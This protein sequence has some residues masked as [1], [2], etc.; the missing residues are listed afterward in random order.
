MKIIKHNPVSLLTTY[1]GK[2]QNN[3]KFN[4]PLSTASVDNVFYPTQYSNEKNYHIGVNFFNF[5]SIGKFYKDRGKLSPILNRSL[6]TSQ[7]N[8]QFLVI[9]Q[10]S[11]NEA[12]SEKML[13]NGSTVEF[14]NT[15]STAMRLLNQN[16]SSDLSLIVHDISNNYFSSNNSISSVMTLGTENT[17]VNT[18]SGM[19]LRYHDNAVRNFFI[20]GYQIVNE[21][22]GLNLRSYYNTFENECLVHDELNTL[23]SSILGRSIDMISNPD[24]LYMISVPFMNSNTLRYNSF[25]ISTP[26]TN[27]TQAVGVP[28]NNIFNTN[29]I[30]YPLTYND[31]SKEARFLSINLHKYVRN[32]SKFTQESY[33]LIF[34]QYKV[35]SDT[36]STANIVQTDSQLIQSKDEIANNMNYNVGFSRTLSNQETFFSLIKKEKVSALNIKRTQLFNKEFFKDLELIQGLTFEMKIS[37]LYSRLEIEFNKNIELPLISLKDRHIFI[38]N[39]QIKFYNSEDVEIYPL[40]D[41]SEESFII[42]FIKTTQGFDVFIND[43][44]SELIINEADL[45]TLYGNSSLIIGGVLTL[46]YVKLYDNV[47]SISEIRSSSASSNGGSSSMTLVSIEGQNLEFVPKNIMNKSAFPVYLVPGMIS[48]YHNAIGVNTSGWD[49]TIS[50]LN[51]NNTAIW[52]RRFTG[53]SKPAST[54]NMLN[55]QE[56]GLYYLKVTG[57]YASGAYFR[58]N[59]GGIKDVGKLFRLN[60]SFFPINSKIGIF[61]NENYSSISLNDNII[62]GIYPNNNGDLIAKQAF[63][64]ENIKYSFKFNFKADISF[65][66]PIYEYRLKNASFDVYISPDGNDTTGNGAYYNPWKT[67]RN[68][69]RGQLIGLLPGTYSDAASGYGQA[70]NIGGYYTLHGLFYNA[71]STPDYTRP[72]SKYVIPANLRNGVTGFSGRTGESIFISA[73]EPG[74]V[75]IAMGNTSSRDYPFYQGNAGFHYDIVFANINVQASRGKSTNHACS[76]SRWLQFVLFVNMEFRETGN[77]SLQYHNDSSNPVGYVNCTFTGGRQSNYSGVSREV[78]NLALNNE[79]KPNSKSAIAV[80]DM[81]L[82]DFQILRVLTD[83]PLNSNRLLYNDGTYNYIKLKCDDLTIDDP[84]VDDLIV[85]KNLSDF[86]FIDRFEYTEFNSSIFDI[87]ET[88]EKIQFTNFDDIIFEELVIINSVETYM[89][90]IINQEYLISE[91]KNK[92]IRLKSDTKLHN[93]ETKISFSMSKISTRIVEDVETII[94]ED[95]N[96]SKLITER[97]EDYVE[98]KESILEISH[99]LIK[100]ALIQGLNSKSK[101]FTYVDTD[102]VFTK[103]ENKLIIKSNNFNL[104]SM[105]IKDYIVSNNNELKLFS[106]DTDMHD[107]N[108][109]LYDYDNKKYCVIFNGT[110]DKHDVYLLE[111]KKYQDVSYIPDPD[112]TQ[113]E[114]YVPELDEEGNEI[115]WEAPLIPIYNDRTEFEFIDSLLDTVRKPLPANENDH[116]TYL[117]LYYDSDNLMKIKRLYLTDKIEVFDTNISNTFNQKLIPH[118]FK[119]EKYDTMDQLLVNMYK[120]GDEFRLLVN[121]NFNDNYGRV[122]TE[123]RISY[124]YNLKKD[125]FVETEIVQVKTTSI[126]KDENDQDIEVEVLTNEFILTGI[127]ENIFKEKLVNSTI[128]LNIF[129]DSKSILVK[130]ENNNFINYGKSDIVIHTD[131]E[132]KFEL[133]IKI[134]SDI[135]Q[136]KNYFDNAKF[137]FKIYKFLDAYT[138]TNNILREI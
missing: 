12:H 20:S 36:T 99:N 54:I 116:S 83:I 69:Q 85:V 102:Y 136:V 24:E 1:Y 73:V 37:R 3:F 76:Y 47:E 42:K 51:Q 122:N 60:S 2:N 96:E 67:L 112:A 128:T 74:T 48:L 70:L 103:Y 7:S 130:D 15:P 84:I 87:D 27:W 66:I 21:Q 98:T 132:A 56:F 32:A 89:P 35:P 125:I 100:D 11:T 19:L 123:D 72:N 90:I 93:V 45:I 23:R 97:E 107:I 18:H 25:V 5:N 71:F 138:F 127:V 137:I 114:D 88:F 86:I 108:T 117:F 58:L 79:V 39:N 33:D 80:L 49:F 50:L 110:C 68:C 135:S 13:I 75:T 82:V 59:C 129:D 118:A 61:S 113:P 4:I 28:A 95:G 104:D 9:M 105:N 111:I 52:S 55:I 22:L 43:N 119:F 53:S 26:T 109:L 131:S 40:E 65:K 62:N 78:S 77:Y 126:I 121:T 31:E 10:S 17:L 8:S 41:L 46:D 92:K 106:N 30:N 124:I 134:E 34:N 91:F 81:R 44:K 57:S 38:G 120:V 6:V 94:D 16:Y 64:L 14:L 101:T 115:P 63:S 29:C 133:N